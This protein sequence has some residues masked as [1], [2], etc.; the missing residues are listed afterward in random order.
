MLNGVA[1]VSGIP[2][3]LAPLSIHTHNMKRGPLNVMKVVGASRSQYEWRVSSSKIGSRAM[4]F[5]HFLAMIK[6]FPGEDGFGLSV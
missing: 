6:V 3:E 4:I 2:W 1:F 5:R